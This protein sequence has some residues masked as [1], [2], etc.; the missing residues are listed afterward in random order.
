MSVQS[1]L[2]FF[3]GGHDLEMLAIRELLEVAR[4]R[5]FDRELAWGA[6]ASAYREDIR[7]CLERGQT[8][9][10]IELDEDLDLAPAHRILVDHHGDRAGRDQPTSLEQVF[11]LLDLP[12]EC[13]TRRLDLIA[14]ND[15][16]GVQG[17]IEAGASPEEITA[18]RAQ[19]RAAQGVSQDEEEEAA[20]AARHLE[21]SAG[22]RLTV[23]HLPHDRTAPLVDRLQ[24]QLGGPGFEN[25]L[26]VSPNELN[27]FGSG[28]LVRALSERYPDGW[29]GGDLPERG[30]WGH[31]RPVSGVI[32]FLQRRL[33]SSAVQ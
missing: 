21:H 25:L 4:A 27:F 23:A 31:P 9:V 33:G 19:D 29:T 15:R 11:A 30:F 16:G 12:E 6:A 22:G 3:L 8:P 5:F 32:D 17:L 14:A 13:W 26:V 2:V 28:E 10:L 1:P 24:P 20:E 18:I 7:S